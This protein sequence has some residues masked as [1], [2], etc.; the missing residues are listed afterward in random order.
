ML[1]VYTKIVVLNTIYNFLVDFFYL[2]L[3]SVA[4]MI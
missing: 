1:T 4:D 2:K 3:F